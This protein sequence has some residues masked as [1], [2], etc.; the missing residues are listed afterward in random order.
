MTFEAPP[1]RGTSLDEGLDPDD[2]VVNK[3]PVRLVKALFEDARAY[4]DDYHQLMQDEEDFALLGD[5]W[6]F[7]QRNS[8]DHTTE[9]PVTAD[10]FDLLRH[11]WSKIS[12][13][14][15]AI[16]ALPV[17]PI[18]D[19]DGADFAKAAIESQIND[20]LKRYRQLRR[21]MVTAGLAA[22]AGAMWLDWNPGAGNLG[23]EIIFEYQRPGDLFI[24]PG[25]E[26]HDVCNPYLIR[27]KQRVRLQDIRR[28][29][30]S[31]WKNTEEVVAD[32]HAAT[33]YARR[34]GQVDYNA[35]TGRTGA[36]P[37]L[38]ASSQLTAE[39]L[40]CYLRYDDTRDEPPPTEYPLD[41]S[42]HHMACLQCGHVETDHWKMPLE[43]GEQG[44]P[45]LPDYGDDCPECD[46]NP[47]MA[48]VPMERITHVSEEQSFLRYP[49]GRLIIIAPSSEVLLYDGPWLCPTRSFPCMLWKSYDHPTD[50]YGQSDTSLHWSHQLILD[51]LLRS[52]YWQMIRNQ[53]VILA[54]LTGKGGP[55]LFQADGKTPFEFTDQHGAVAYFRDPLLAHSVQ[56]FQGSGLAAGLP[57][58]YDMIRGS[59]SGNKGSGDFGLTPENSKN[60]AA[61]TVN[62]LTQLGEIPTEDHI[63]SLQAEESIF[64]GNVLDMII[65]YWTEERVIR[66]MGPDGVM[67]FLKLKGDY[68]PNADIV[69]GSGHTLSMAK[70]EEFKTFIEWSQLDDAARIVGAELLNLSPG[71]VRKYE[72]ARQAMIAQMGPPAAQ[73]GTQGAPPRQKAA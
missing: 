65:H 28:M 29:K 1:R 8:R 61:S 11:K 31:G 52:G 19:P 48:A 32:Q 58:L 46:A 70:S 38:G 42:E 4:V 71:I 56:H 3:D 16:E 2:E 6:Q 15:I 69:V 49:H 33:D 14:P 55:G 23:G 53:D 45:Q 26:L 44:P 17:D 41:P 22:R 30:N 68:I 62:Q 50:P 5:H 35:R 57:Q 51:V 60:I 47:E 59:F 10:L 37:S 63:A 25:Y 21:K 73:P 72:L 39:L 13:S 43:E 12:D 40:F 66:T 20:P 9:M 27:R 34:Q 64:F 7:P 54:P 18:E 67:K 36:G 24:C